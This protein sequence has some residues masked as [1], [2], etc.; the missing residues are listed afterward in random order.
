MSELTPEE[1]ALKDAEAA[2]AQADNA[3]AEALAS[4]QEAQAK[5]EAELAEANARADAAEAEAARATDAQERAEANAAS[6]VAAAPQPVLAEK[7]PS[8]GLDVGQEEVQA[9]VDLHTEKG[10]IGQAPDPTPNENYSMETPSSAPTPETDPALKA[11]A[12]AAIAGNPLVNTDKISTE[13]AAHNATGG[14]Q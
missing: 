4:A 11:Q 6:N 10:Y 14:S 2:K 7:N 8:P 13:T 9:K 5:A 12:D 1:Q 3:D